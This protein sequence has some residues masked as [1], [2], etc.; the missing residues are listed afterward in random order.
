MPVRVMTVDDQPMFRAIAHDLIDGMPGFEPVLEAASGAEA[1]EAAG[2]LRP[3]LVLV[4]V[5]MPGMSGIEVCRK[6]K[7]LLATAVI[8]LVTSGD[9]ADVARLVRS[10]GAVA[11]L[12]K[13]N[14]NPA[15]I[16]GIWMIH[17]PVPSPQG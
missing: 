12:A 14:I 13:Q 6:L 9:C 10:C 3:E 15:V 4:D 16:R 11:L 1:I 17:G 2:R 7:E 8:V 5:R